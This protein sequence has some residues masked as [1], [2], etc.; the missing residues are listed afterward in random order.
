[1]TYAIKFSNHDHLVMVTF[2][3]MDDLVDYLEASYKHTENGCIEL[4]YLVKR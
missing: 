1:M 4:I 3:K 2:D